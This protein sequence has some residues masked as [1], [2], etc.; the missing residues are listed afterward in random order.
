MLDRW[1][2]RLS[3]ILLGDTGGE[4]I[5][6]VLRKYFHA[7]LL[8]LGLSIFSALLGLAPPY[9]TKLLIDDGL[10]ARDVDSL[11]LWAACLFAG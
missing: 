7:L 8:V 11:F 4:W 1:M 10:M 5:A 2:I 6:P 3:K 9:L